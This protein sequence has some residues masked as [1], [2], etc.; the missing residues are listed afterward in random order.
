MGPIPDEFTHK[1]NI[2]EVMHRCIWSWSQP[3]VCRQEVQWQPMRPA[4]AVV[5][6]PSSDH[7]IS[8]TFSTLKF[9]LQH[10]VVFL[11]S[12]L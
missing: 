10:L 1:R 8:L 5:D 4:I 2:F 7:P 9:F 3:V 6:I 11:L 12:I